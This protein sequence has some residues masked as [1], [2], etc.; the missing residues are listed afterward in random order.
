[1]AESQAAAHP[2][3]SVHGIPKEQY[4]SSGP[5]GG[6]PGGAQGLPGANE[7]GLIGNI[8][9]HWPVYTVVLA[10]ITIIVM[11]WINANNANNSTA[12]TGYSTSGSTG[13][14]TPADLYGSQLDA[15]YQQM[16][17]YQNTTNGLLQTLIN[18]TTSSSSSSSN[19]AT[20]RSSS[21]Q[22]GSITQWWDTHMTGVPVHSQASASSSILSFLPFGSTTQTG[23]QIVQG[24]VNMGNTG[25]LKL[26]N[27]G[28][29]SLFDVT[30]DTNIHA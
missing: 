23:T 5:V 14:G 15:D 20:I 3:V 10:I 18:N 26:P 30:S 4:D 13:T 11:I 12:S 22:S 29:I 1:M 2:T 24:D 6:A 16:M 8:K 21:P 27:G 19:T 7:P 17:S 28:Y 9:R 25:W